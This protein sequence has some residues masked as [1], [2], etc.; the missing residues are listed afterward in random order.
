M[1][2]ETLA[3][4][5]LGLIRSEPGSKHRWAAL[6]QKLKCDQSDLI[7]AAQLLG[8]W[9]YKLRVGKHDQ[10]ITFV[11]APDLLTSTEI[12]YNLKTNFIGRNLIS[13]RKVKST[14]DIAAQM[15]RDKAP[16]G[17][18]ITSEEQTAGRG[19]LGRNWHSP[20]GVGIYLSIIL[21]PRFKPEQAP[22]ISL[23]TGLALSETVNDY[24][25]GKT[26]IK[27]PNDILVCGKKAAGILTEL[28]A[29]KGRIDYLIVGVGI[30]VN[31]TGGMFPDEIRNTAT[32]IRRTLRR[33]VNRVEL[34]K[35]FLL[36]FERE[37]HLYQKYRL[38]KSRHR[39][40]KYSS[41][42]GQQVTLNSGRELIS[43]RAVD[44]D[45]SGALVLETATGQIAV[46]AGEVTLRA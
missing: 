8:D 41:L 40:L 28:S 22:G 15:A 29:D 27:W 35:K 26:Q 19:R 30:N 2:S 23:M 33:R 34:L 37:Y 7:K 21:R 10:S 12:S 17:T 1:M 24:L 20:V 42:L 16:E 11:A 43:G 13:Y 46:N 5:L 4:Q 32:S 14:N 45:S 25:P 6:S 39:L 36:K 38:K 3:D 31:Q 9:G 18:V 44:I